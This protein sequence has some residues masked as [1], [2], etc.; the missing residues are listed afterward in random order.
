MRE[1]DATA[2]VVA[3]IELKHRGAAIRKALQQRAGFPAASPFGKPALPR[4]ALRQPPQA[5]RLA[6]AIPP[7]S[8]RYRAGDRR[9]LARVG[10]G[11]CPSCRSWCD[12]ICN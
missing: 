3:L 1:A 5:G 6:R 4:A 7:P 11:H 9:A 12:S 10:P 2:T 8:R